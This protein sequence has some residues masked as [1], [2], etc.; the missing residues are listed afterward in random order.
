MSML[1]NEDAR[2]FWFTIGFSF[3]VFGTG[4]VDL[5]LNSSHEKIRDELTNWFSDQKIDGSNQ[6]KVSIY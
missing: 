5:C 4:F 3:I 1:K 2:F 6:R